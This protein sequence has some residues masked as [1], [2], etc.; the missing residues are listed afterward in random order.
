[1]FLSVNLLLDFLFLLL[2]FLLELGDFLGQYI[3]LFGLFLLDL[4]FAHLR[5][6]F[7]G[8]AELASLA[9]VDERLDHARVARKEDLATYRAGHVTN[10]D[11]RDNFRVFDYKD[12]IRHCKSDLLPLARRKLVDLN[13]AV[14][15]NKQTA[16]RLLILQLGNFDVGDWSFGLFCAAVELPKHNGFIHAELHRANIPV[17]QAVQDYQGCARRRL[18]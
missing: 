14:F 8:G 18:S 12:D 3:Q 2:S 13:R 6:V 9:L 5:C 16:G 10:G 17:L 4:G 15:T 11:P 1:M 7:R